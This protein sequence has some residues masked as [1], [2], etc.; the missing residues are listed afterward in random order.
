MLHNIIGDGNVS[1]IKN[2]FVIDSSVEI[3]LESGV[4]L[5][6][7]Y[8]DSIINLFNS[9]ADDIVGV[10]IFDQVRLDGIIRDYC[11][12]DVVFNVSKLFLKLASHE[13]GCTIYE[14]IGEFSDYPS[15]MYCHGSNEIIVYSDIRNIDANANDVI[16]YSIDGCINYK[17][18][19]YLIFDID[20]CYTVTDI[21]NFLFNLDRS[22]VLLSSNDDIVFDFAVG[23]G[24]PFVKINDLSLIDSF[25]SRL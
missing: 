11:D 16:V 12:R 22:N 20:K 5:K 8:E 6:D 9:V 24:I 15:V 23:L 18:I 14:Y 17:G 2:V 3:I 1:K 13:M 7:Y 10:E 25:F 19:D 4:F 21:L